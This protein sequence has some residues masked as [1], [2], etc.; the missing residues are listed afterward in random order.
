[1][2]K[3]YAK[4]ENNIV[5][6]IIVCDDSVIHEIKGNHI[7]VLEKYG[8]VNVGCEY[9]IEKDK[10]KLVNVHESW[11]FN[12]ESFEWEAPIQ[13]PEGTGW[14]WNEYSQEWFKPVI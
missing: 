13:K 12:E 4:I 3:R 14:L 10:F 8:N 5:E 2:I 9:N 6:N 11:T 7:E 1:M